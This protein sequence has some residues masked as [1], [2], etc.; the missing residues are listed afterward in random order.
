MPVFSL[1]IHADYGCRST[2][3]CCSSGWEVPVDP[4]SEAAIGA[5][6]RQGRL[7]VQ[8]RGV[9]LFRSRHELPDAARVVF[10]L[11]ASGRCTF[12]EPESRLCAVHRQAGPQALPASC[13]QFPRLA[14]LTPLG[15]FV[16][17]SH[18][19]PTAA[20]LLFRDEVPRAIDA[21]P[22]AFR[23]VQDWEGLDART[24]WPPLLR[25]G[26]LL[27][28][29]GFAAWQEAGV[30]LL[31]RDDLAPERAVALLRAR[32]AFVAGWS[33][34][35]GA[36]VDRIAAAL[37][38]PSPPASPFDYAAAEQSWRAVAARVPESL[39]DAAPPLGPGEPPSDG[40]ALFASRVVPAWA[41]HARAVRRYLAA[42]LFAS[43][44][45]LQGAGLDAWTRVVEIALDVLAVEAARAAAASPSG[46]DDEALLEA[47]RRADLLI[48][49]LARI[50]T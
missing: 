9:P 16:T 35:S 4:E 21:S 33:A 11:D 1:G 28:W 14:L 49:H 10:G 5:A 42:K 32:T 39:R 48:V 24:G 2:G 18:Y 13:R 27:G 36:L 44:A 40:G 46:L 22:R 19:C 6:L 3:A 20:S 30:R 38:V 50:E 12:F 41:A 34:S 15:T 29:D 23:E 47:V 43:W 8:E 17:L 25:P 26:V 45:A 7:V 37:D 31:L